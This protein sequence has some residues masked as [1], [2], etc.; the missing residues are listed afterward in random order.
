MYTYGKM[1]T[2]V[3]TM[4]RRKINIICLHE[5]KQ[6]SEKSNDIE[7]TRYQYWLHEKE[8]NRNGVGIL[9]DNTL[10]ENIVDVKSVGDRIIPIMFVLG[11]EVINT[12][13]A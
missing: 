8:R 9:A 1:M 6:V 12:I 7:I 13:S 5:T 10:E 4:I 3:S 2:L 11:E